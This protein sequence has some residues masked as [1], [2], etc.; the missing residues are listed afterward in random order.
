MK[1]QTMINISL[2]QKYVFPKN[3]FRKTEQIN[4]R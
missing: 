3:N 4:K 2:K 1:I